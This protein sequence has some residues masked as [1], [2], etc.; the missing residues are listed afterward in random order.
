MSSP[1]TRAF[2]GAN[3]DKRTFPHHVERDLKTRRCVQRGP[4]L[5]TGFPLMDQFILRSCGG[6]PK[7]NYDPWVFVKSVDVERSFDINASTVLLCS[8]LRAVLL[9]L[10]NRANNLVASEPCKVCNLV[11]LS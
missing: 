9:L 5:L 8:L 1:E 7:T 2:D 10:R 3:R 11:A 4:S 6:R